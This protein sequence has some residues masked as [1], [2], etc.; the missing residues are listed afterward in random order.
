[1]ST[2]PQS[3]ES[4]YTVSLDMVGRLRG[5]LSHL[6][7]AGDT[8]YDYPEKGQFR[9]RGQILYDLDQPE[10]FD[11]II[12]LF[13]KEGF[14]PKLTAENGRHVLTAMPFTIAEQESNWKTPLLLF[15]ATILTTLMAG[16]QGDEYVS[17]LL[18]EAV[19]GQEFWTVFFTNLWRG[20]PYSVSIL[21]ILG[22]HEL[23]H[24]FAARYHK[25]PASLPYFIPM[26]F[27]IIGTMGAFIMQ[28]GPSKNVR[29]QFDVGASG[30]LAGMI[31]ALPIL[32]Y[33]LATSPLMDLPDT[34]YML[35]GNS[36]LY[37]LAK[38]A[39][40]GEMLPS[41]AGQ[42]VFI[43]QF[44]W[45]GW[46]GLLVTGL[47][48]I[49]VGQLDGGRV[50]Q[51][52]F[53]EGVLRQLYWPIIISMLV[54]GALLMTPTWFV[55][56]GLLYFFGNRYDEPLDEVTTLDSKRRALAIFTMVLFLLVFTPI[57]LQTITP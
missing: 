39:V 32:I 55:W 22:A 14:T 4:P 5:S 56:A 49:P 16:I 15:V 48:L 13:Q 18:S 9:F 37:M 34:A 8:T 33:G 40:F 31:F 35:E 23:G 21:L 57:P 53:G 46:T 10:H 12:E 6:F 45:A 30:P 44:A 27:S 20:W 38:I 1:M 51:V 43:N 41:S 2:D 25:V 3:F 19:T 24:F 7:R 47:N 29:T 42:D 50:A 17:T 36:I 26:P 28:K 11:E 54:M 52:L